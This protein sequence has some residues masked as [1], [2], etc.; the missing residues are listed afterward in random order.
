MSTTI[1]FRAPAS[2]T[3]RSASLTRRCGITPAS[4]TAAARRSTTHQVHTERVAY[5]ATQVRA[6][7]ELVAYAERSGRGRQG[8]RAHR[9]LRARLCRRG[10]ARA[11]APRSRRRWDDFGL[12]DDGRAQCLDDGA[13]RRG[14]REGLAQA[15]LSRRSA[16]TCIATLGVNNIDL[17]DEV[18]TLTR[19]AARDFAKNEVAPIARRRSTAR[20]CSSRTT[21]SRSSRRRASSAPRSL[22]STAAPAWATSR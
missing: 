15:R 13:V 3:P 20:T 14:V 11:R 22:R 18:A 7:R 4:P 1:D 5:L 17:E 9:A 10:D 21:S 8:G 12:D 16:A 19:D 6:A 2:S